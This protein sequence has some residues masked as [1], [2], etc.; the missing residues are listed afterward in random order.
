MSQT[1]TRRTPEAVTEASAC[2][3]SA[4]EDLVEVC[5]TVADATA[6]YSRKHPS[7]VMVA[8]FLMGF[9]VGWKIKPW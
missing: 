9:Y 6:T 8:T 5:N 1:T 2:V 7:V 3:L 4:T